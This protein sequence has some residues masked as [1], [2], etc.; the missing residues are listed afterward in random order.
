MLPMTNFTTPQDV[1][2]DFYW[3]TL[4]AYDDRAEK[5][6]DEALKFFKEGY[7]TKKDFFFNEGDDV[8]ASGPWGSSPMTLR[9][10]EWSQRWKKY[11]NHPFLSCVWNDDER[12]EISMVL[13]NAK[14]T[15]RAV[16][17]RTD[18]ASNLLEKKVNNLLKEG[19]RFQ[20][21]LRV[22]P[23]NDLIEGNLWGKEIVDGKKKEFKIAVR[24]IWNYRYGAN[25]AN[26][27]LTQYT[28]FRGSRH[29]S[30]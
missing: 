21:S 24:M 5:F 13:P 15:S 29:L 17:E 23:V 20:H 30:S 7:K 10:R 11:S 27:V 4:K 3:Q 12:T 2:F 18:A 26:G 16:W 9:Y 14:G 25:S 1:K 8:P 6:A 19:E 28:Q 22:N